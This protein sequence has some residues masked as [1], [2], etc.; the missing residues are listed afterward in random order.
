MLSVTTTVVGTDGRIWWMRR[1]VEW[2]EP[3][4]GDDFEHDVSPRFGRLSWLV[5]VAAAWAALL[6][7]FTPTGVV[8]LT[9]TTTLALLIPLACAV[10]W[11]VRRPWTLVV[12]T[13][14][15]GAHDAERYVA[16][17]RGFKCAEEEL[18]LASRMIRSTGSPM[19]FSSP[20]QPVH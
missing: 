1:S 6:Y 16:L 5:M 18:E 19:F 10:R 11:C 7:W 14:G 13:P 8:R 20:F 2:S 9:V 17:I 4:L 15:T 12:E 3:W